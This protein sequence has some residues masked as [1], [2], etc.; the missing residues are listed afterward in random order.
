MTKSSEAQKRSSKK[1]SEENLEKRRASVSKWSRCNPNKCAAKQKRW[2]EANPKSVLFG[3]AKSRAK[4]LGREFSITL[5]DIHIPEVCPVLGTPMKIGGGID[6]SPSLDRIDSS[7][8]Y[9][10]GNVWVISWLANARKSSSS[11]EDLEKLYFAW[12]A[13]REKIGSK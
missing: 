7:K 2:R 9:V 12:K 4:K 8:G 3:R 11:F 13:I 10:K 5:D 6:S 1:W